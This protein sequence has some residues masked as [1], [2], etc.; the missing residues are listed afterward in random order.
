MTLAVHGN[1]MHG[2]PTP[3]PCS[4]G[5]S[6]IASWQGIVE[7]WFA[8]GVLSVLL[9]ESGTP[10]ERISVEWL[11]QRGCPSVARFAA[12]VYFGVSKAPIEQEIRSLAVALACLQRA[13]EIHES[14]RSRSPAAASLIGE[15]GMPFTLNVGD[16]LIGE[17]YRL[18][19]ECGAPSAMLQPIFQTLADATRDLFVQERAE[20]RLLDPEDVLAAYRAQSKLWVAACRMALELAAV[21]PRKANR[22]LDIAESVAIA[23]AIDR[24]LTPR[25]A[26]ADIHDA[27]LFAFAFDYADDEMQSILEADAD[28]WRAHCGKALLKKAQSKAAAMRKRHMDRAH[29]RASELDFGKLDH[30]LQQFI[31]R[32]RISS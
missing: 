25:K 28:N 27:L 4:Q 30:S 26:D 8:T 13:D 10:T 18:I 14:V 11:A 6:P 19:A 15:F 31:E 23:F 22:I 12:S 20:A 21:S 24:E 3:C 32:M 17:A 7:S 5:R 9:D 2:D 16:Y 29:K 1:C